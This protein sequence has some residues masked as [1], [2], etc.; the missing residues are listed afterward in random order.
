MRPETM[1]K[2]EYEILQID[3]LPHVQFF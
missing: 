3:N 2:I 1:M